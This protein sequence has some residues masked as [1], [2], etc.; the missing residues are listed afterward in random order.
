MPGEARPAMAA[1]YD[2]A[3]TTLYQAPHDGFVAERKRLAAE[4]KARGQKEAAS[5]LAKLERPPISAWAVNQLYWRERKAFDA[6][7]ATAESWRQGAAGA[8][9]A[10]RDTATGLRNKAAK[11]LSEAGHSANEATL[12]RVSATLSALAAGGGFD[13]DP[14]G[15]LRADRDPPGFGALEGAVLPSPA[16]PSPTKATAKSGASKAANDDDRDDER[17]HQAKKA[18]QRRLEEERKRHQAEQKRLQTEIKDAKSQV[19]THSREL[20][21]LEKRHKEA[22]TELA[23]AQAKLEKLEAKLEALTP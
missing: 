18:E 21:R 19:E 10:H 15:A 5:K 7:L 22:E 9:A 20:E 12:R 23:R 6:L 14:P 1:E 13:P 16:S 3:L 11:I 8:A 17:E 4:L 2:V